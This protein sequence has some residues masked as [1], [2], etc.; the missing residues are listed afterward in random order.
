VG[1]DGKV[2]HDRVESADADD[3]RA[4]AEARV[5]SVVTSLIPQ[6]HVLL[7]ARHQLRG[8]LRQRVVGVVAVAVIRPVRARNDL[9]WR[10]GSEKGSDDR[11]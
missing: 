8:W 5:A 7:A 11:W 6:N 4:G 1:W 10:E 2:Q 3:P 9:L